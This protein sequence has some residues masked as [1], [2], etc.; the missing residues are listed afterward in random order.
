MAKLPCIALPDAE[1]P[2][3]IDFP[4]G[5]SLPE[6]M[7]PLQGTSNCQRQFDFLGTI[8]VSLGPMMPIISVLEILKAILDFF[9]A[10]KDNPMSMIDPNFWLDSEQPGGQLIGSFDIILTTLL[11]QVWVLQFLCSLLN[12]IL[13]MLSCILDILNSLVEGFDAVISGLATSY[14]LDV[15]DLV[16]V[17]QCKQNNDANLNN[18][19]AEALGVVN[20][21]FGILQ[22]LLDLVGYEGPI[23]SEI[24]LNALEKLDF[25]QYADVRAVVV[26]LDAQITTLQ[27]NITDIDNGITEVKNIVDSICS[28]VE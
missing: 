18:Q 8:S 14:E 28:I 15:I 26:E 2:Q 1:V 17:M 6:Q 25:S 19:T 4:A 9:T 27:A 24:N 5:F 3:S 7:N 10:V 22:T 21:I 20:S 13:N 16:G 23:P 11:P 12:L